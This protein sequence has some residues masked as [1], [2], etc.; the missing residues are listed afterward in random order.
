MTAADLHDALAPLGAD[1]WC[2]RWRAGAADCAQQ[3]SEQGVTYAAKI[4]KPKRD[5]LEQTGARSLRHIPAARFPA[6]G[7]SLRRRRTGPHQ[8]LSASRRRAPAR[9]RCARRSPDHCL[10]GR[11]IRILELQRAASADEIGGFSARHAAEAAGAAPLMPRYNLPSNMCTPF[12]GWQIQDNAPT[13]QARGDG[14]EAICGD[15]SASWRWPHQPACMRWVRSPIAIFR[16]VSAGRLR[17]GR[18]HLRP[19]PIACLQ[20]NRAC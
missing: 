2:A 16:T 15:R 9:R 8:I 7:V 17:D 20:R 11:A 3:A 1:L 5:R 14:G 13:V 18:T 19:H 12:S 6:P 10:C 4:D